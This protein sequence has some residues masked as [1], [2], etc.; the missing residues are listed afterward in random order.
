MKFYS[1][2]EPTADSLVSED[3]SSCIIGGEKSAGFLP[4]STDGFAPSNI[5]SQS[6][7]F[8]WCVNSEWCAYVL[9]MIMRSLRFVLFLD[10]K[11]AQI[12]FIE[13]LLDHVVSSIRHAFELFLIPRIHLERSHKRCMY[14]QISMNASAFCTN[15]NTIINRCPLRL[16]F[17]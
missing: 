1:V 15:E 2:E 13:E 12:I 3:E 16:F 7:A 8:N 17:S 14:S 5:S 6:I 4:S 10:R 11:T 9:A